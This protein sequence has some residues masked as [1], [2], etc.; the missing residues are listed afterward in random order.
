MPVIRGYPRNI[1]PFRNPFSRALIK[2]LSGSCTPTSKRDGLPNQSRGHCNIYRARPFIP[3]RGA[4][5]RTLLNE[6]L[7]AYREQN[8]IVRYDQ[9]DAFRKKGSSELLKIRGIKLILRNRSSL[10]AGNNYFFKSD[11]YS[12]RNNLETIILI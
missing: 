3:S 6:A 11:K 10:T 9:Q 5:N 1:F 7:K 8:C 2:A 4:W 12:L